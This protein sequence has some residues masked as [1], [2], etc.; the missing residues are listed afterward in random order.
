MKT[1]IIKLGGAAITN[2]KGSCQL[3]DESVL[4]ALVQQ[5]QQAHSYLSAHGHQ[6]ILIHGAGSFG[7][8]QARRYNL[9]A[10]WIANS[11]GLST[12]PLAN[13]DEEQQANQAAL[14]EQK[15][16]FAHTRKCLL[17]LHL[18][19]LSRLQQHGLPVLG[20]SPFDYLET[21]GGDKSPDVCFENLTNRAKQY[22]KLGFIPML[23]GDAVL[24]RSL[25]CTILSGDIIMHK[26]VMLI[27]NITRCVFVTDVEGIYDADPKIAKRP[28]LIKHMPIRSEQEEQDTRSLP[29]RG[30][31]TK[32]EANRKQR[33]LAPISISAGVVDVTGGMGGKVKWA[34]Q[35]ILDAATTLK[36]TDVEIV[37]CKAGS[38][39]ATKVMGLQP[40][41]TDKGLPVPGQLMTVFTWAK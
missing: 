39:E 12:P 37:I 13:A 33:R 4:D 21:D 18:S 5:I 15:A 24:D 6:L 26:L 3:A 27:P 9:K 2:K 35:I 40:A 29:K 31:A 22:L 41:L 34:R 25:G 1:V 19:L 11:G 7:H 14:L 36:R 38:S 32:T 17:E 20:L 30:G 10:G 23:H 8:P 28:K 16:G